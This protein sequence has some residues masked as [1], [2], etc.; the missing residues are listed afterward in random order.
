MA[1]DYEAGHIRKLQ[2]RQACMQEKCFTKWVNN[3]FW[4]GWVPI[5]LIGPENIVDRDQSPILGLWIIILQFQIPHISLDRKEFGASAAQLSAKEMWC[6]R[7]TA[8]Y[9]SFSRS[10]SDGLGFN[11]LLHAH[12]PDLLEYS[13]LR[14]E[15]PLHNL[16]LAFHVAEQKLGI[17][18]LLDPEDVATPQPDKRSVMTYISLYYHGFSC[19]HHGQTVQRRLAKILLQLQETEALQTQY[20]QL[21]TDLLHRIIEMQMQLE[22]RAFPDILSAMHQLLA[23]FALFRSQEKPPRLQLFQLQTALCAQNRRP[24]LPREGL[25]AA[26]A[27]RSQALQQRL[28]KLEQ[29]ETLAWRFQRKAALRE[30]FLKDSEQVLHQTKVQTPLANSVTEEAASQRLGMLEA[31]ILPQEGLF[32]AL[33]QIAD[34]LW[35]ERYHSWADVVYRV[36]LAA[37]FPACGQQRTEVM[38]LLQRPDLLEAQVLACGAHMGHLAH[39]TSELDF[40]GTSVEMLQAKAQT[41]DHIYQN[42]VS[43]VRARRMLLEQ[44][45]QQ[46]QYLH[47]CEEKEEEEEIWL[48]N[49]RRKLDPAGAAEAASWLLG[50][51]R[52]VPGESSCQRDQAGAGRH[53]AQAPH[54]QA[55]AEDLWPRHLRLEHGLRRAQLEE[56]VSMFGFCSSCGEL[57]SWVEKQAVLLRA[58]QPQGDNLEVMQH[59]YE[60]FLTALGLGQGRWAE[61]SCAEQLKQRCPENAARI[62]QM[63]EDLSQRWGQLEALKEEKGLQRAQCAEVCSFLQECGPMRAQLR[64]VMLWLEP[65]EP[66]CAEDSCVPSTDPA[67]DSDA[68][69]ENPEPQKIGAGP[70]RAG[71]EGGR[72]GPYGV[73]AAAGASRDA[74]EAAEAVKGRVARRV[75]AQAEAWVQ[76]SFLQESR[77]LRLWMQR[78]QARLRGE[79]E[80]GDLGSAQRLQKEHGT[81]QEEICLRQER[82][83]L[84]QEGGHAGKAWRQLEAQGRRMAA[85]NSPHSQ[86]VA[87]AVRLLGQ[88]SRPQA[89]GSVGAEPG[90][91]LQRFG[92][93]MGGFTATCA[94]LDASC[95]WAAWGMGVAPAPPG[96]SFA[97]TRYST[98]TRVGR[99]RIISQSE[100][101]MHAS[102]PWQMCQE[103]LALRWSSMVELEQSVQD[104]PGPEAPG[105]LDVVQKRLWE[106]L[107]ALQELS[108][109]WGQELEGTLR[110]H[111]FMSKAEED[112][113]RQSEAG[114]QGSREPGRGH[115]CAEF[116]KFQRQVEV[117]GQ[118]VVTCQRLAE[119]L[120]ECGHRIGTRAHQRQQDLQRGSSLVPS[121][122]SI[123]GPLLPPLRRGPGPVGTRGPAAATRGVGAVAQ[124]REQ[125]LGPLQMAEPE[126]QTLLEAGGRLQKLG[127]GPGARAVQQRQQAVTQAWKVLQQRMQGTTLQVPTSTEELEQPGNGSRT[128]RPRGS[129]LPSAAA[130][131]ASHRTDR[132]IYTCSSEQGEAWTGRLSTIDRKLL[133]EG[134]GAARY[135]A[136]SMRTEVQMEDGSPEPRLGAL[137]WLQ[138]ELQAREGLRQQATQLGQQLLHTGASTQEV[139]DGLRTLQEE[140]E[141]VSQAW[142]GKQEPLQAAVQKQQLFR[143]FSPLEKPL[144]S[145]EPPG[146]DPARGWPYPLRCKE[147]KRP[148]NPILDPCEGAGAAACT[149]AASQASGRPPPP[150]QPGAS[151]SACEAALHADCRM[152]EQGTW[153]A[154]QGPIFQ[155]GQAL[156]ALSGP[157]AGD[158]SQQLQALQELWGKLR[159]AV[160]HRDRDLED[161]WKFL[162]FL[163]QV[164]LAEAW[165]QEKEGEVT[166]NVQ[167]P[168]RDLHHCLQLRRQL[169]QLHDAMLAGCTAG[170]GYMRSI[171]D[172]ALQLHNR[173]PE[174]VRIGHQRQLSDRRTS[175]HGDL[176]QYQQRLE[177]T[178]ERPALSRELDRVMESIGEKVSGE[179]FWGCGHQAPALDL[180][181]GPFVGAAAVVDAPV[182]EADLDSVQRLLRRQE[183]LER[184]VDEGLT[185]AQHQAHKYQL[186]VRE[187]QARARRLPADMS[188]RGAPCSPEGALR[189]LEEH[190]EYKASRRGRRPPLPGATCPRASTCPG[191][192]CVSCP[193]PSPSTVGSEHSILQVELGVRI[194]AVNLVRS[195]GQRLLAAARH[196]LASGTGQAL[197]A[198]EQELSSPGAWQKCEPQLQQALELQLFLHSEE[199]VERWLCREEAAPAEGL[200]TCGKW[201]GP[202]INVGSALGVA[203][204][205]QKQHEELKQWD[206]LAPLETLVWRHKRLEEGL[207]AQA[208]HVSTLEATAQGLRQAGHPEA[209]SSL[210]RCQEMNLAPE[211]LLL[212]ERGAHGS[213]EDAGSLLQTF[214]QDSHE[215]PGVGQEVEQGPPE[216]EKSLGA[217]EEGCRDPATQSMQLRRQQNLQ[218]ELDASAQL[219]Q[220][221]QPCSSGVGVHFN[222]P[223][224]LPSQAGRASSSQ[225]RVP[226]HCPLIMRRRRGR[227]PLEAGG[228]VM[229]AGVGA[230]VPDALSLTWALGAGM[231]EAA[232][233]RTQELEELWAEL[234]AT[235]QEEEAPLQEARAALHLQ[236]SLEELESW[237]AP[238]EVELRAPVGGQDRPEV[239]ELL[240]AQVPEPPRGCAERGTHRE[241]QALLLQ[242]L[243]DAG[244]ETALQEKLPLDSRDYGQSLS[245]VQH[246]QEK[247]QNLES[248]ESNHE[249]L[250]W[251]AV[252]TGVRQVEG[253]VDR[254]RVAVA[255]RRLL[256]QQA[257]ETREL[258]TEGRGTLLGA[259]CCPSFLWLAEQSPALDNKDV[260][261]NTE[262]TQALRRRLEATKRDLEGFSR[263]IG[264]LQP[265]WRADSTQTGRLELSVQARAGEAGPACEG[266]TGTKPPSVLQPLG[267]GPAPGGDRAHKQL[268]QRA[269][270]RGRGPQEQLQQHQLQRILPLDAWLT[271]KLAAAESQDCGRDLEGVKVRAS[272]PGVASHMGGFCGVT[273]RGEGC[274]PPRGLWAVAPASPAPWP[275]RHWKRS[276]RLS[277]GRSCA[278][279]GQAAGPVGAGS[280]PGTRNTKVPPPD[281]SP[282]EQCPGHLGE[283]G[284]GAGRS[285]GLCGCVVASNAEKQEDRGPR[286]PPPVLC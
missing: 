261:Q 23:A 57:G 159:Q 223:S 161:K 154:S 31:S 97:N 77:Q 275:C 167:D 107:Q 158:T 95:A 174:E 286:G 117:G 68:R 227:N 255:Q 79:E 269:E 249:A 4:Q 247:H 78:L 224:P 258:L 260:G 38:E 170:H 9:A 73:P 24:F 271:S 178:L 165:I 244:E 76:R 25:G 2:A 44:N 277:E 242:P 66:G 246:L 48:H 19:L 74:A 155:Q 134:V 270:G 229:G 268:P 113:A 62:Q 83:G 280:P 8:S 162:E 265:S 81:L 28:L 285:P 197:A 30:S 149:R 239:D 118:R 128:Q 146:Q 150:P 51:R 253:A 84:G 205:S 39:Q 106:Q 37:S 137:Q 123:L 232:A 188:A 111:E 179:V 208:E 274:R 15:R 104:L 201:H 72:V 189:L 225:P 121:S 163:Q 29:L 36:M 191:L 32:Q 138:L 129:R 6:Q 282:E 33:A 281:S 27:A 127:Q 264:Q 101:C 10:W 131:A 254:L 203:A 59:K 153:P 202:R 187:L 181:P 231:T 64:D 13:S 266:R 180:G 176:R 190:L 226:H 267:T 126:L 120:Q 53:Q 156:L 35:Q 206:P 140:R 199:K 210:D 213:S 60:N 211:P 256:L 92:E 86:E 194:D 142:V 54:G 93:E 82:C 96:G 102:S 14:P 75:H 7:K 237:L 50:Q 173:D 217:L 151:R 91:E 251:V 234:Q 200:G 196:P 124:G 43:L 58:L 195:P 99:R 147:A 215:V 273:S 139:Q 166:L 241:A 12:R 116:A 69:E 278:W 85:I 245:A 108:T 207:R 171:K 90:L 209:Q 52:A 89:G 221:L 87:R 279:G 143:R 98:R 11:A 233:G 49:C 172:L 70:A 238:M 236:R 47:S 164:E 219:P 284:A 144:A 250:T 214:L 63:Q 185:G 5:P 222:I 257:R 218:A 262:A 112:L 16:S 216:H 152:A 135:R 184:E 20:E 26:E 55:G 42:L 283:A 136:A 132:T 61:G 18:Q 192:A 198:L 133:V 119:N 183:A 110:F 125:Q 252:G 71:A 259:H 103:E 193:P 177:G 122:S 141:Q 94:T 182:G 235:C 67:E 168:D 169:H 109:T 80:P 130:A 46:V 21:V 22:A 114:G 41:L 145:Q 220:E 248:G 204:Q 263:H 230:Q 212:Q 56:V 240:R 243:R 160:G 115:L 34:D 100:P 276:S 1:S 3:N 45:P 65:L 40:L 157:R 175:F 105:Q 272:R 88:H 17:A 228:V 148:L 186:S